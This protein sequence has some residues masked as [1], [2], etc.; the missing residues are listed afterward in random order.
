MSGAHG[1]NA[2]LKFDNGR[3][4]WLR[5][6]SGN[7]GV[8]SL[9]TVFINIVKKKDNIECQTLDLVKLNVRLSDAYNEVIIRSDVVIQDLMAA[10]RTE[11]PRLFKVCESVALLDMIA[12]F[13]QITTMRDYVR[14]EI[15][16][17]LAIQGARHPILDKVGR[18]F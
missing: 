6:K 8:G 16:G 1:L 4:Y 10:L 12:S 2:T 15:T 9:P 18:P 3:K 5:I 13:A 11:A 17:T 14:P 7:L